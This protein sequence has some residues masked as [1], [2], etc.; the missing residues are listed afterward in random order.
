MQFGEVEFFLLLLSAHLT[1][2]VA[3]FVLNLL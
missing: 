1:N 3:L 2:S